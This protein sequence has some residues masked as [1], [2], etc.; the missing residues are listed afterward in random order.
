MVIGPVNILPGKDA[1]S[2]EA[3]THGGQAACELEAPL[4]THFILNIWL[5][6]S[7]LDA[8]RRKTRTRA[9][10]SGGNNVL[11]SS[12]SHLR[13]GCSLRLVGRELTCTPLHYEKDKL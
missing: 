1:T 3:R 5:F 2:G 12:L 7:S 10:E 4:R 8:S 13:A 11:S 9:E 6:G